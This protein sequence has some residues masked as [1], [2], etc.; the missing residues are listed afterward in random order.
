MKGLREK[1]A[2]I[3]D[4]MIKFKHVSGRT[5]EAQPPQLELWSPVISKGIG[6]HFVKDKL[7]H[8]HTLQILS[9]RK[10]QNACGAH[11]NF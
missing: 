9:K 11:F 2:E 8:T 1:V 6:I 5:V 4:H 7:L 10:W 3:L